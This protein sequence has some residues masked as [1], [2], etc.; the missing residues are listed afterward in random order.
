MGI[1]NQQRGLIDILT[2]SGSL[3]S[4]IWHDEQTQLAII[5][6]GELTQSPS[7]LLNSVRFASCLKILRSQYDYIIIDS[8]PSLLVSDALIIGQHAD[9]N[10]LITRS[11]N[12]KIGELSN[13]IELLAKHNVS[14][15][16]IILNQESLKHDKRYQYQ[17]QKET[18]LAS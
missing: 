3:N 4:Y 14:T 1:P 8:P 10:I 11:N 12:S 17:Y 16:G 9:F 6:A 15:D 7:N 13:T 2:K 18:A 5:P